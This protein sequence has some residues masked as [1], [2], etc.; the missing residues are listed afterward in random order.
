VDGD[1]HWIQVRNEC[2]RI[3]LDL[4]YKPM[5][6]RAYENRDIDAGFAMWA[7]HKFFMFD[8]RMIFIMFVIERLEGNVPVSAYAKSKLARGVARYKNVND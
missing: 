8:M 1:Y 2:I 6:G 4:Q 3:R 5:V 7:L